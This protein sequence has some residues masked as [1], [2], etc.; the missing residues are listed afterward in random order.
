MV[1]VIA[2]E[3]TQ[4][5]HEELISMSNKIT[6][7]HFLF[8][9]QSHRVKQIHFNVFTVLSLPARSETINDVVIIFSYT[10]YRTNARALTAS[11][12]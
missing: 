1:S 7:R 8:A 10:H 11:Q 9:I 4:E 3:L 6:G 5:N 12:G 2:S